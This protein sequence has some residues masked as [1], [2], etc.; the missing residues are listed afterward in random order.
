METTEKTNLEQILSMMTGIYAQK[1]QPEDQLL[2]ELVF[3]PGG[4]IWHLSIQPGKPVRLGAGHLNSAQVRF[5]LSQG[6]LEAIFEGKLT[7]MTAAGREKMTDKTP[8]DFELPEGQT[9]TPALMQQMLKFIQRFFNPTLPE[10]IQLGKDHARLVHGAYAI[11]LFYHQ[12]F[13]SAWYHLSP[14][15]RLNESGDTNPFPQAFVF[16]AGNGYAKIADKTFPVTANTAVFIPPE[17]EHLAW[18]EDE[19]GLTLIFL[20]WGEGA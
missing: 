20:A 6:T 3:S 2:L 19:A 8:L 11:P 12:G 13:R 15:Q 7:G 10:T 18:T 14:G 1:Q 4:E 16:V 5:H 9:M 17:T